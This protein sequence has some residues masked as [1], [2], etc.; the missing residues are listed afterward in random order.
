MTITATCSIATITVCRELRANPRPVPV[1]CSRAFADRFSEARRSRLL[2][3]APSL[4]HPSAG[5]HSRLSASPLRL[6]PS[7][8]RLSRLSGTSLVHAECRAP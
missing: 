5:L 8:G 4:V 7:A 3:R 2:V 6:T 1:R